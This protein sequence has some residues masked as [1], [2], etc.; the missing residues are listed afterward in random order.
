MSWPLL[1]VK[2]SNTVISVNVRYLLEVCC[3]FDEVS[4]SSSVWSVAIG[5]EDILF[6]LNHYSFWRLHQGCNLQQIKNIF[7]VIDPR[8]SFFHQTLHLITNTCASKQTQRNTCSHWLAVWRH[9]EGQRGT[10]NK[11]SICRYKFAVNILAT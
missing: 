1:S 2:G 9:I 7:L 11:S 10:L 6:K 8:L 4:Q 5:T 3:V